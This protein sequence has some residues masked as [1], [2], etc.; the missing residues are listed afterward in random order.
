MRLTLEDTA[1]LLLPRPGTGRVLAHGEWLT[2]VHVAE[3]LMAGAPHDVSAEKTADN[4]EEFLRLG[5]S[6]R[7]WR[8]RVLL[9]LIQI[10]SLA[11]HGRRFSELSQGER[12]EL[13]ETKW[14]GGHGLWRICA[15]VKNLVV[16]GA[17][18]D[19]RA[20]KQTGYVPVPLRPRFQK[21]RRAQ[22]ETEVA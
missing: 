7:A 19:R 1:H 14:I 3:V 10:S 4:I 18:G 6:R 22:P 21:M 5:R 15:K 11:T 8:V 17:Y 12:R 16:L 20:E 9:N 13:I 2:L